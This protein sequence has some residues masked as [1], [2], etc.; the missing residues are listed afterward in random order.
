MSHREYQAK[1][2]IARETLDKIVWEFLDSLPR[3]D[4]MPSV[5]LIVL[6]GNIATYF[7]NCS[8]LTLDNIKSIL[9]DFIENM[10]LKK[11]SDLC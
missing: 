11:M 4:I 5:A 7:A 9:I 1:V 6:V 8:E 2:E 10:Q 3:A